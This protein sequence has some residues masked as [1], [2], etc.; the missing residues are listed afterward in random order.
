METDPASLDTLE[1]K[2]GREESDFSY[3]AI[4]GEN[5]DPT[6]IVTLLETKTS[7]CRFEKRFIFSL[8][9]LPPPAGNPTTHAHVPFPLRFLFQH[10]KYPQES[11]LS[12]QASP[13]P[14]F[15]SEDP[16]PTSAVTGLEPLHSFSDA[17]R[18]QLCF[19]RTSEKTQNPGDFRPQEFTQL[20]SPAH[21]PCAPPTMA[22][23][24]H[25]IYP[26]H[27]PFYPPLRPLHPLPPPPPPP[28]PRIYQQFHLRRSGTRQLRLGSNFRVRTTWNI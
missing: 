20:G 28:P 19:L 10:K 13:V 4:T 25:L 11:N 2:A 27:P 9:R 16:H 14:L 8:C 23:P 12:S 26:D 5:P 22:P 18:F 6:S 17:F 7:T 15:L 21:P 24:H 3:R 1:R